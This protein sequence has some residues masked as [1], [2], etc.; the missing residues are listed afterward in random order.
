MKAD[1]HNPP[2]PALVFPPAADLAAARRLREDFA[3]LGALER[4]FAA[5]AAGEALLA[6]LGGNA[7]YLAELACRES[8]CLLAI[9]ADGPTATLARLLAELQN[10]APG[11]PRRTLSAALRGAKRR[12]VGPAQDQPMW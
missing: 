12:A 1:P 8:A 6:C 5:T 10:L 11:T 4:A 9:L 3:A 7:P 2:P